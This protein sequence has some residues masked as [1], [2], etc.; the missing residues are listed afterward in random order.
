MILVFLLVS[1][2]NASRPR[3]SSPNHVVNELQPRS[4]SSSLGETDR[5]FDGES[6]RRSFDSWRR[7][8]DIPFPERPLSRLPSV[9]ESNF[10]IFS[11]LCVPGSILEYVRGTEVVFHTADGALLY[12]DVV[13]GRQ[14]GFS[15]I[16]EWLFAVPP[17]FDRLV[18]DRLFPHSFQNCTAE[19]IGS[20]PSVQIEFL[21]GTIRLYPDDYI[22]LNSSTNGCYPKYR[23][24][25]T[26]A[27]VTI[28]P[29]SFPQVRTLF[30]PDLLLI[31]D[32][33][34]L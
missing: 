3:G 9:G 2:A 6:L 15:E 21:T 29:E 4:L 33:I 26:D 7:G 12:R 32:A 10:E 5:I 8:L 13:I 11:S 25:A 17:D 34:R 1:C 14:T 28:V 24:V 16:G 19:A 27:R 20:L 23:V 31:G 30:L 18:L 22:A